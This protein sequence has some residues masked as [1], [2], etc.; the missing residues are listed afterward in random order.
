MSTGMSERRTD[1]ELLREFVRKGDQTAFADLVRRHLDLVYATALRKVEDAGAAQEVAQNVFS[2]L[3]RKAWRFASDDSLPAWLYKT[4]LLEAKEW[5]R[6]E[7]R[8]RRRE[9]TAAELGTT[10]K[11]PEEQT[12]FRALL[13]LLDE[14]L[15][16]LREKDRTA[17]LLRFYESQSLREVGAALGTSEDTA[18]KRVAGALEK[19]SQFFQRRGFKTATAAA[20]AATLQHTAS[21]A[22]AATATLVASAALQAAPPV[23]TGLSVWLARLVSLSKV[24]AATLCV[25]VTALPV[26]WQWNQHRQTTQELVRVQTQLAAAQSQYTILQSDMETLRAR[27]SGLDTSLAATTATAEQNA[28]AAKKFAQWKEKLRAQLLAAD[29]RWPGDSPFVRIP[30]S[31]LR[32]ISVNHPVSPPGKLKPEASELLGLTPEEHQEIEGTLAKHFANIDGLVENDLYET[33]QPTHVPMPNSVLA[34]DVWVLPALGDAA[35]TSADQLQTELK[36]ELGAERWPQVQ[37]ELATVGTDTLRRVLSLDAGTHGQEVAVWILDTG[38]GPKAYYGWSGDNNGSFSSGGAPLNTFLP[39]AQMPTGK[40]PQQLLYT[41][42]LP[43]PVVD[44]MIAWLEQQAQSRL[45]TEANR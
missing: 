24:Q 33:N 21:S 12:A 42:N 29:Y 6:G 22:S 8:R 9:Q 41:R 11:T 45:G 4:T 37:E 26:T 20:A 32:Q 43:T 30:K 19:L 3:A 17:L 31:A 28:A 7:L 23:L 18:Q 2:A 13:P 39:G 25:L 38:D 44:R 27:A 5:L 35:K 1:F 16:S 15:L 34:S 40:T 14:A 36:N 10:M